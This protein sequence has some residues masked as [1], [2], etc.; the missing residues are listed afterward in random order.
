MIGLQYMLQCEVM[1]LALSDPKQ[2]KINDSGT[3]RI[4]DMVIAMDGVNTIQEIQF[5]IVMRESCASKSSKAWAH[6]G[7]MEM[8][9]SAGFVLFLW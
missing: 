1:C 7:P 8:K 6:K 3:M 5:L 2:C 4:T 9:G